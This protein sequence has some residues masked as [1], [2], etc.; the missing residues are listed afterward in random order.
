MK[1]LK[2]KDLTYFQHLGTAWTLAIQLFL[3]SLISLVHGIL[4]FIWGRLV[5]DKV[6]KMGEKFKQDILS[7]HPH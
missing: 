4:P 6:M 3:L 2:D 7:R 1:H 5:S